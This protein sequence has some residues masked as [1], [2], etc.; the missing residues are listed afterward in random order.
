MQIQVTAVGPV[1]RDGK[2]QKLELNYNRDGKPTKRTLVNIGK[3]EPVFA[4]LKDAKEG[5]AYEIELEQDAKTDYWNWVGVKHVLA[6]YPAA[7]ATPAA[8]K[9]V[10]TKSTYETPEER[11]K[12]QVLIVRQSSIASAIALLG[13]KTNVADI[14]KTAIVF[15]G[16]VFDTEKQELVDDIPW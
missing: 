9:S 7:P 14:L 15:E 6:D 12:R 16:H 2:Y 11:A 4:L 3:T 13:P 5:E 1:F 10:P 8:T